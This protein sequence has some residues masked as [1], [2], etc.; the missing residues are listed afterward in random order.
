MIGH[1]QLQKLTAALRK[2]E[3]RFHAIFKQAAAGIAQVSLDG[4]WLLMNQKIC[5]ILGYSIE[6]LEKLTV[7]EISPPEEMGR[8]LPHFYRLLAGDI[9]TYSTEKRYIHK[10]GWP[11]WVNLSVS[12]VRDQSGAPEYFIAVVQDINE[13]KCAEEELRESEEKFYKVFKLAPIGITISTLSDGR[14]VEMNEAGERLSGYRREEVIGRSSSEFSIWK[15][16]DERARVIRE[17]LEKGELRDREMAMKDRS[18]RV[19][20]GLLSAVVIEIRGE[21]H[22]LCLVSD[23]GDRKRIQEALLESEE[24]FRLLADAAPVIIWEA[25]LDARLTFLNKAGL[26]YTGREIEQ[27]LGD[28]WMQG[29]HPD[30]LDRCISTYLS[31]YH[32]R[33]SFSIEYRLR[34]ADGDYGWIAETGVPRLNG[35]GAEVDYVGTCFDIT[36]RKRVKKELLQANMLLA[37]RVAERTAELSET[38]EKLQDEI[39]ERIAMGEALHAE[40]TERVNV[41]AELRD[42]ELLLLHQS[43]LAAMGEMIGNI[44][45]QWRQPLNLLGLLAQDLPMTFQKGDFSAEYLETTV[46]KMLETIRHM[47]QT[48]DDFRNFF[49]PFKERADFRVLDIVE[50]TISLLEGSFNA[51]QIETAVTANCDPVVN[52]Y[53]NEFSQ[54]LLNI[55]VNARD[56]L[57]SHDVAN[58]RIEIETSMA[59]GRCVLT[60][61]DNAGGIPEEIIDRIFE[62]YFSTK[63][64]EKGTGVGLFMSKT[65]IEKN[66]GGSLTVRNVEDGAEFRIEMQQA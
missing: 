58:P 65:I 48:I 21:K 14:F 13:R 41:Q 44:A 3:E 64:P 54:V 60:I 12:L 43:R 15:D 18:G 34:R 49:R 5:D 52:G 53:P 16:A 25:G 28:G 36:E 2:S 7:T 27:E 30:D 62:P 23:M 20:W 22:L 6:E 19:F 40:T 56:A 26:E 37:Q 66:M 10:G 45:H 47:S 63:G 1:S 38:V 8:H 42:K 46:R 33:R 57:V 59:G 51:Q 50:K 31:A 61:T 9:S 55:M 32:E 17:L 24:R 11:I 4:H 35:S 29:V 39:N